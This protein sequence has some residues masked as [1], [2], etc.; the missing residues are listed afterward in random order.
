[1]KARHSQR[2]AGNRDRAYFCVFPWFLT[3]C[4]GGVPTIV[5]ARLSLS[6]RKSWQ[7]FNDPDHDSSCL[8]RTSLAGTPIAAVTIRKR[9]FAARKPQKKHN[10]T[11]SI[12]WEE[13]SPPKAKPPLLISRGKRHP[14][15]EWSHDG[16][17]PRRGGTYSAHPLVSACVAADTDRLIA[18]K[19]AKADSAGIVSKILALGDLAYEHGKDFGCFHDSWGNSAIA[20][21]RCL[22]TM[23]TR[24]KLQVPTSRIYKI[25]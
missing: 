15:S 17:A 13:F 8:S 5:A 12:V 19:I 2:G 3:S 7:L 6:S 25:H 24:Q 10:W 23:T 18:A 14:R 21:C 11:Q 20:Y 16:C 9:Y 22:E 1:M 4:E